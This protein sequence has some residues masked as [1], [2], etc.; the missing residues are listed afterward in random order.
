MKWT[1][2]GTVIPTQREEAEQIP[3]MFQSMFLA[4]DIALGQVTSI[5]G[6]EPYIVQN[7]VKRGFL[8]P[9]RAKRY[10]MN[11]LCRILNINMLKGALTMDRI[12]GLLTYINGQLNDES[13]DLIDDSELYFLFVKL[14]ARTEELRDQAAW[15]QEIYAV[16]EG[17]QEKQPGAKERVCRVLQIMLAAWITTNMQQETERML[18]EINKEAEQ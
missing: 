9:P 8:S 18:S 2:P 14:A 10:S 6:L 7:W 17:F 11:Q 16:L 15:Q 3:A 13:D 12:C 1:I 5:S 4:G